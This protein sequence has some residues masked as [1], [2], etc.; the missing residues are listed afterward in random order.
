MLLNAVA[1]T[2]LG[3][4]HMFCNAAGV[5]ICLVCCLNTFYGLPSYALTTFVP[6]KGPSIRGWGWGW[7]MMDG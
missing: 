2:I 5:S 7:A 1:D 3:F 4:K 6:Q